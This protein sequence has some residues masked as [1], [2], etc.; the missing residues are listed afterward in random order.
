MLNKLCKF[1]QNLNSEV[2]GDTG[3]IIRE[4]SITPN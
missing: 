3:S 2:S 1:L 4:N